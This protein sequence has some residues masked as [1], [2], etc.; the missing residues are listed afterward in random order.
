[1]KT[2]V[3]TPEEVQAVNFLLNHREDVKQTLKR[4]K[5]LHI[6]GVKTQAPLDLE[7]VNIKP[8]WFSRIEDYYVMCAQTQ[9]GRILHWM[10]RFSGSLLTEGRVLRPL[11]NIE[12][13][14]NWD[15]PKVKPE[16]YFTAKPW[17]KTKHKESEG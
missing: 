7:D 16:S 9:D 17:F 4:G 8:L 14:I 10:C 1:L 13:W 11:F 3:W 5:R 15:F 6:E 12:E 2:R